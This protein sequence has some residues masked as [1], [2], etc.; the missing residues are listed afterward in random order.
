M[1]PPE[2]NAAGTAGQ[3]Q[4]EGQQEGEQ[5]GEQDDGP[6]VNLMGQTDVAPFVILR[7]RDTP[8][9]R[10]LWPHKFQLLYKV[11]GAGAG[12]WQGRGV[13]PVCMCGGALARARACCPATLRPCAYRR[14]AA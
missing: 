12:C 5:K 6:I 11:R 8:E 7:L 2:F 13:W 4:Q 10:Q 3:G 9:T 14:S 1:P